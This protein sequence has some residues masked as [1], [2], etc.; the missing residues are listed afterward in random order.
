MVQLGYAL[1]SEEHGPRKL[2]E[3]A[4]RAERAGFEIAML[5]DHFHPWLD[6]QGESPFVWGVLG[7]IAMQTRT[8]R[9]GTGVTCPIQR[10]HPAIIAQAGATSKVPRPT[11]PTSRVRSASGTSG[12][13]E[14]P[15]WWARTR[16]APSV[17]SRGSSTRSAPPSRS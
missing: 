2:V 6:V 4:V 7:A 10:I 17:G 14:L 5:S 12:G 16:G 13:A 9:V 11:M 8:L 3:L 15:V 1:S